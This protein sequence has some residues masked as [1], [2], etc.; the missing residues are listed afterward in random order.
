[1]TKLVY[2]NGEKV[3]TIT[4]KVLDD[5]NPNFVTF[6]DRYEGVV[7]IPLFN[8]IRIIEEAD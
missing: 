1:M 7:K 2:R 4:G 8:I 5:S 6:E 3:F